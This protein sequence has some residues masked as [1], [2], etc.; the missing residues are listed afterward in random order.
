VS[1]RAAT[2]RERCLTGGELPKM[3]KHPTNQ[4][5]APYGKIELN[6]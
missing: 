4:P 3:V 2:V 5:G 1:Y 6:H